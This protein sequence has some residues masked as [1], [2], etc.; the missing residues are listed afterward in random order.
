MQNV[1]MILFLMIAGCN[2]E[3]NSVK[4]DVYLTTDSGVG[5]KIGE[6]D[7]KDT[8][9]GLQVKVDLKDLPAGEHGFHIHENPDCGA[10]AD[11]KGNMQPAMMAGG[12]FDPEH[13]GKHLGPHGN[14][15][16]GDM[17]ALMVADDGTVRTSFYLHGLT[18]DE[19]KNRSIIIHAGGDNYQ[20][21]PLPLGGGGARIACGI[22]R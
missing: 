14:G 11:D 7:F 5:K 22:I 6:V 20:D 15:H 4:T 17:P 19:I 1:L 12:H 10:K 9:K 21:K 16:K 3:H 18:V 13:T 8:A 2:M